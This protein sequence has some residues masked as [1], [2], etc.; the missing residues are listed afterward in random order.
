MW[1]CCRLEGRSGNWAALRL[2]A[3][4]PVGILGDPQVLAKAAVGIICFDRFDA[5]RHVTALVALSVQ[6]SQEENDAQ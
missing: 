5:D 2:F 4:P 1:N 6:R 3:E